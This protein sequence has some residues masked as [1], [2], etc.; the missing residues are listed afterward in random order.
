MEAK[1]RQV[2]ATLPRKALL[3]RPQFRRDP[4]L[5]IGNASGTRGPGR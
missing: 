2:N 5:A 4:F 1:K 3:S